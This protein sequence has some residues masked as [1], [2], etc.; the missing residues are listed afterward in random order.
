MVDLDRA[1]SD[2]TADRPKYEAFGAHLKPR[3]EKLVQNC[4]LQATID[5]RAKSLESLL[6]RLILKPDKTY[7]RVTD[8][9]GIRIV[10]HFRPLCNV[11]LDVLKDGLTG[12]N[13]EDKAAVLG[14]NRVGYLGIHLDLTLS[15]DDPHAQEFHGLSAEVQ[16][17]TLAEHLWAD[18]S[19]QLTY[20][21][22]GNRDPDFARRV[23]ITSGALELV[24][25]EFARLHEEITSRPEYQEGMILGALER[26]FFRVIARAYNR[27]LSLEV[28]HALIPLYI[29]PTAGGAHFRTWFEKNEHL[30]RTVYGRVGTESVRSPFLLQPEAFMILDLLQHDQFR[31]RDV[32]NSRFPERELEIF[33]QYWGR[34]LY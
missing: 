12:E 9:L 8:K 25:R 32:W 23:M 17:R 33:A 6:G 28:I 24:D 16:V 15:P 13:I 27:D 19:H 31:L 18:I 5:Y 20:K 22:Y 30:V 7:A 2:W 10:L 34:T 26:E 4:G 11:G 29:E 14:E 21:V 1:R 3:L